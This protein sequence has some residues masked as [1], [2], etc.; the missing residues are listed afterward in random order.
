MNLRFLIFPL[1]L[2]VSN[3]SA[4]N[5]FETVDGAAFKIDGLSFTLKK[6]AI[7]KKFGKPSKIFEPKY[8]CG[9]LS[10]AEQGN[11]YYSLDY[12]N[13]K[14][15]GN[16]KEGY[17]LEE[18]RLVPALHHKVTFR[19]KLIS[20]KTTKKE[21]ESIFGFKI[22]GGETTT[23]VPITN[24]DVNDRGSFITDKKQ[25]FTGE[26][27]LYKKGGDDAF[28]FTFVNGLLSKIEYWS[29]C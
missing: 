6:E 1:L 5:K 24:R 4:Q 17:L 16:S 28:V 11:K 22:S 19:N 21:F 13:I 15:T 23:S 2:L 3:L 8:E 14:F 12:G 29:P 9:F 7:L 10:E 25:L 18:I 26:K 27:V 20:H